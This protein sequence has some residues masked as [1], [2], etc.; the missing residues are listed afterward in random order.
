MAPRVQWT[1]EYR[2][3]GHL[4]NRTLDNTAAAQ[5]AISRIQGEWGRYVIGSGLLSTGSPALMV[6]LFNVL[7]GMDEP[8]DLTAGDVKAVGDKY[9]INMQ[10]DQLQGLQQIF[11]QYLETIIPVGDTQLRWGMGVGGGCLV[12]LGLVWVGFGGASGGGGA[13]AA[14]SCS[15]F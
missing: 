10:K 12:W 2:Y 4:L 15:C 11:G 8:A 1:A 6:E 5:G 9:G 7:V 13:A 14:S 3:L